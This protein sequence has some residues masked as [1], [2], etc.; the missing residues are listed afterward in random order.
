MAHRQPSHL[1]HNPGLS[2]LW[3]AGLSA[4][5]WQEDDDTVADSQGGR[6]VRSM[7]RAAVTCGQCSVS[8]A[9][10]QHTG[11]R[12]PETIFLTTRVPSCTAGTHPGSVAKTQPVE[13]EA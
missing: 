10:G 12:E 7:S 1:S 5:H 6:G 8:V 4:H 3:K 13:L 2:Q 9:L 11:A